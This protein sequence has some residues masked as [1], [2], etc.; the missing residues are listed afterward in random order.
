MPI[1]GAEMES[2]RLVEWRVQPGDHVKRGD[3]VAVV[4]TDKAAIEVEIWQDGVIEELLV[5]PDERVAVGTPIARLRGTEDAEAVT[6]AI[7]AA[8]R[9]PAPA[10]PAALPRPEAPAPR[11]GPLRVSPAARRLAEERGLDLAGVRGSG[12]AGAVT[13]DDVERALAGAPSARAP[14]TPAAERSA[15]MRRAIAAAMTRSKR[16]IPHYYLERVIVMDRA[17]EW[18]EQENARL[19]IAE[20]LLPI[21]LQLKAVALAAAEVPE[22]NGHWR[23][24]AF[25][26]SSAVH[27]GVAIAL[28]PSGLV[29]PAIHD[30]ERKGLAELMREFTDLVQRARAGRLRSSELGDPTLTVNGLGDRGAD[31]VHGIIYPPQVALIGFGR[32]HEA[33]C[34]EPGRVVSRRVCR[35][36]LAA[37]HRVSDG[38]RGGVF[39]DA[40]ERRLQAPERL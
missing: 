27:A 11:P 23:D 19:A 37:D 25:H 30:V 29:A 3:I 14:E 10:P 4:D 6:P 12:L 13:R 36:S 28:R 31:I 33:A 38:H 35:A 8:V 1:L 9:A 16:E 15:A 26:G 17:L 24:G 5:Q 18:L 32:L 7:A 39:L 21:V 22:M 20:R 34:A 2:G 40:L